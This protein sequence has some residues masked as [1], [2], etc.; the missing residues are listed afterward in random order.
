[1]LGTAAIRFVRVEPVKTASQ[2]FESFLGR[3]EI[4]RSILILMDEFC[5][6]GGL[7]ENVMDLGRSVKGRE[8][9]W[10]VAHR[11]RQLQCLSLTAEQEARA[12]AFNP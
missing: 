1:M 3:R 8:S 7:N 5:H 2:I 11:S 9:H 10:P 12:D 6:F 4:L